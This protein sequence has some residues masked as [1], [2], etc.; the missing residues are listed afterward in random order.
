MSARREAYARGAS[1]TPSPNIRTTLSSV[2]A[3]DRGKDG[4]LQ[5]AAAVAP[6]DPMNVRLPLEFMPRI[7]AERVQARNFHRKEVLAEI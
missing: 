1:P 5:P 7:I 4:I 6:R 3:G 2:V